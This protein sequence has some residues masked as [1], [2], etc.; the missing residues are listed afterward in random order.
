MTMVDHL[1]RRTWLLAGVVLAM[2]LPVVLPA[3][4]SAR[5]P[6]P[7]LTFSSSEPN[8]V[9]VFQISRSGGLGFV[10]YWV[11]G[12]QTFDYRPW[13]IQLVLAGGTVLPF[14]RSTGLTGDGDFA[15]WGEGDGVVYGGGPTSSVGSP[16]LKGWG[17]PLRIAWRETLPATSGQL[18][19]AWANQQGPISFEFRWR[20][21]TSISPEAVG[22]VSAY[23]MKDFRGGARVGAPAAAVVHAG[24]GLTFAPEGGQLW[25]YFFI[26]RSTAFGH[27]QLVA[28][29]ASDG[30]RR[31]MSFDARPGTCVC[32]ETHRWVFTSGSPVAA[33]LDLVGDGRRTAVFVVVARL[34]SDT[35]PSSMWQEFN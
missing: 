5:S 2:F 11:N 8:G 28:E 31:E 14:F 3:A 9:R 23:E 21:G 26:Y 7:S 29:R 18:V 17:T 20:P 6:G 32:Y 16:D 13:H 30:L 19:V 10:D 34:P 27:G 33:A 4:A 25:G 1:S 22:N 15:H 12:T 24:D 35:L